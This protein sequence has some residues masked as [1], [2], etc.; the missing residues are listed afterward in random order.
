MGNNK[1]IPAMIRIMIAE[2]FTKTI[3][4]CAFCAKCAILHHLN[5]CFDFKGGG[6]FAKLQ[7]YN[8]S[9]PHIFFKIV[10]FNSEYKNLPFYH[11]PFIKKTFFIKLTR[12]I[13]KF[14]LFLTMSS[15]HYAHIKNM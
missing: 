11:Y 13:H 5:F 9:R 3:P 4:I 12:P 2:K 8:G 6:C 7:N 14:T 10:A 1:K 15:D